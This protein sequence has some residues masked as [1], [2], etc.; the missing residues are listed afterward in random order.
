MIKR[1]ALTFCLLTVTALAGAI[2]VQAQTVTP[3]PAVCGDGIVQSPNSDGLFEKC[4]ESGDT[5]RCTAS[6]GAKL[7]GWAWSENFG[8]L[9]LN[10]DNCDWKYLAPGV[11]TS[12]C[13]DQTVTYYTQIDANNQVTG[14]SWADSIGWVCFGQQCD[15]S[16]ICEFATGGCNP[17]D[18]GSLIPSGGWAA[19]ATANG[20]DNP[21]IVGWAKAIA[22]GDNG[23][24][25]LGCDDNCSSSDYQVRLTEGDFGG[26]C[27]TPVNLPDAVV[28]N[29]Y[30]TVKTSGTVTSH[31]ESASAAWT[32]PQNA[33]T[34]DGSV[35]QTVTTPSTQQLSDGLWSSNFGF[36]IPTNA[37]ITGVKV[38][39]KVK[40][41]Y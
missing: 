30:S 37:V 8:W 16:R 18:Y 20:T 3:P 38:K 12:A 25:S 23:L 22:L 7:M 29:S 9:S 17:A 21:P 14:F 36:N 24:I 1:V 6:C 34:E 35:A 40:A 28:T 19:T 4:D 41:S 11:S 13:T 32:N 15:P 33:A 10:S 5:P 31:S 39:F 27:S 26:T 2:L